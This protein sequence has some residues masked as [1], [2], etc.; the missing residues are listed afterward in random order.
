VET[1]SEKLYY[2]Q[3][4][5]AQRRQPVDPKDFPC[6]SFSFRSKSP[7]ALIRIVPPRQKEIAPR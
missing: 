3:V 5:P 1:I 4:N 6:S 2:M 7:Q